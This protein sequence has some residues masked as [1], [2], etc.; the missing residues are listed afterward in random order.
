[1]KK[2]N[3]ILL[4]DMVEHERSRS[5][6]KSNNFWKPIKFL[7]EPTVKSCFI[8]ISFVLILG[9]WSYIF[10]FCFDFLAISRGDLIAVHAGIGTVLFAFIIFIAE[11]LRDDLSINRSRVLLKESFLFPLVVAEIFTFLIFVFSEENHVSF[12]PVVVIAIFLIYSIGRMISTLLDKYHFEKRVTELIKGR[13]ESA[14]D[15]K[16]EEKLGAEIF[17]RE[18]DLRDIKLIYSPYTANSKCNYKYFYEEE[19]GIVTD[20]NLQKLKK[21]ADI[22]EREARENGFVFQAS[23]RG[24]TDFFNPIKHFEDRVDKVDKENLE[25]ELS[26]YILKGIGDQVSRTDN[27]MICINRDV[28]KDEGVIAS[29][30]RLFVDI[31]KIEE[32]ENFEERIRYEL[33]G[34]FKEFGNAVKKEDSSN[35]K[36]F[37]DRNIDLL[38]ALIDTWNT[39]DVR[40]AEIMPP[41]KLEKI[42]K[43]L[44]EEHWLLR[45]TNKICMDA[46]RSSNQYILRMMAEIPA[47]ITSF[48][49][50]HGVLEIFKAFLS[51][52][53]Y[54]YAEA[55][56][57][58]ENKKKK[59]FKEIYENMHYI[60]RNITADI[61]LSIKKDDGIWL[62]KLP[63]FVSHLFKEYQSLL[64]YSYKKEDIEA[65]R[66]YIED[67]S[68]FTNRI[69]NRL[70]EENENSELKR[71]LEKCIRLYNQMLFSVGA[72]TLY[73]IKGKE[74]T[75]KNAFYEMVASQFTSIRSLVESFL[76]SS[77]TENIRFWGW[78]HWY[79]PNDGQ[80]HTF[81]TSRV[82]SSFV[83]SVALKILA[84]PKKGSF[85][86]IKLPADKRLFQ[87]I[88]GTNGLEILLRDLHQD[89]N[90][91]F[92]MLSDRMFEMV[93]VF[94]ELL[95]DAKERFNRDEDLDLI[96]KS[97]SK[98]KVN[99]FKK[100]FLDKHREF[101][102][103]REIFLYYD[104]FYNSN[105]EKKT[106]FI[107]KIK[108]LIKKV[109]F[110]DWKYEKLDD[111]NKIVHWGNRHV[112]EKNPFIDSDTIYLSPPGEYFGRG[113]AK[114]EQKV[115][116][117]KLIERCK[118]KEI[119]SVKG[120]LKGFN[121]TDYFILIPPGYIA[122]NNLEDLEYSDEMKIDGIS[123]KTTPRTFIGYYENIPVFRLNFKIEGGDF[124]L[125]LNH[126]KLGCFTQLG[127]TLENIEREVDDLFY[128]DVQ[129]FSENDKL[130]VEFMNAK[131]DWLSEIGDKKDQEDYLK[132]HVA[133]TIYQRFALRL[134][135]NFEGYKVTL[136]KTKRIEL[137]DEESI[138]E[139]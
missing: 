64:Y 113:L 56:K 2:K 46:M 121:N 70:H 37:F 68:K 6:K 139:N 44:I 80:I 60:G 7:Y 21:F 85:R 26:R 51:F 115:I 118:A 111:I 116:L 72:Y 78:D 54:L 105:R 55:F 12:F 130:L 45:E 124:F 108:R 58:E 33:A 126:S 122:V 120:F 79:I 52:Y 107:G 136:K 25:G 97:L 18:L 19:E 92:T 96:K 104:L 77:E 61:E 119:Q 41:D 117:D 8:S 125:I 93:P 137:N 24:A 88:I 76:E 135:R 15:R 94:Q 99:E 16:F 38:G 98:K 66:T 28:I 30:E 84:A 17:L 123:E 11:S 69:F 110:S 90:K 73:N 127:V 109:K 1:M 40:M 36:L 32:K 34:F 100:T 63:L 101:A 57:Y 53:S 13:I 129:A 23:Y 5:Q 59:L 131:L 50:E 3:F 134:H 14:L 112:I 9:T 71:A 138:I 106:G 75:D 82:L 65:F 133:I 20:I 89:N 22:V 91:G 47:N 49:Y 10:L 132:K 102:G 95:I 43:E 81:D 42:L 103:L 87:A 86:D 128:F 62:E 35:I 114:V 39:Y 27:A 31:F 48:S 29:L 83:V 4:S 74:K 67:V